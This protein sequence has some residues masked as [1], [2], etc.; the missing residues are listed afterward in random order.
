MSNAFEIY[1]SY[2]VLEEIS[3][4]YDI[5]SKFDAFFKR[6]VVINRYI[7]VPYIGSIV[8]DW[9]GGKG[10]DYRGLLEKILKYGEKR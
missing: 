3:T 1:D 9:K 5:K 2:K 10:Q 4:R 7:T 8:R 6:K